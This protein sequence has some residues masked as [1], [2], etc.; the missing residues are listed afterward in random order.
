MLQ[1]PQ[2]RKAIR[3]VTELL[4][5]YPVGLAFGE[6]MEKA[7]ISKPSL[8][9]T[10]EAIGAIQV[11]G[12]WHLPANDGDKPENDGGDESLNPPAEPLIDTDAKEVGIDK[13]LERMGFVPS[14]VQD[15]EFELTP[16]PIHQKRF[17]LI[18]NC[19]LSLA[20]DG[21]GQ[22]PALAKFIWADDEGEEMGEDDCNVLNRAVD[23]YSNKVTF[24][25]VT[26]RNLYT[27]PEAQLFHGIFD[28]IQSATARM[29]ELIVK[30][31]S[32]HFKLLEI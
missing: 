32:N 8:N 7:V 29:N 30:K 22:E 9:K 27:C 15:Q 16:P 26:Y 11:D 12:L 13:A 31:P 25:G 14:N 3:K 5:S 2:Q 20:T 10:L 18:E 24:K 19:C 17:I 28:D 1:T 21:T 6:I 23:T 4:Q